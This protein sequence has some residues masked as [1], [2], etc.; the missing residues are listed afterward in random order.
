MQEDVILCSVCVCVHA[1][2]FQVL[3]IKVDTEGLKLERQKREWIAPT[4]KLKENV[5]YR[6]QVIAK[7]RV[8]LPFI[9]ESF[10][11]CDL[12]SFYSSCTIY[13]AG[14]FYWDSSG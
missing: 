3:I 9:Y 14:C 12:H 1:C 4:E 7:V 2:H 13:S 8:F 10:F 5:D 6:H 11:G